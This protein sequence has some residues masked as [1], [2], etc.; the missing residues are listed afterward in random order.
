MRIDNIKF[1]SG[2]DLPFLHPG[3]SCTVTAADKCVGFLGEIHPEVLDKMDM[4]NGAILFELDLE[5]LSGMFSGE[6][7]SRNISKFPSTSRDVAF[8]VDMETQS[9]TILNLAL[10]EEKELLEDIYIFDVYTG[11]GIPEGMKSLAVKFIYRSHD[12]TL[13][14]DEVNEVHDRIVE[15]IAKGTGATIR[16]RDTSGGEK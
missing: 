13:M 8:V 16:G 1:A 4:K 9:E 2:V 15:K 12:K 6:I 11:S 5:I 10:D 14:D 3:K 7:S